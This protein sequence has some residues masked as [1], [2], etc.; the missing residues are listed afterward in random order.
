MYIQVI[1]QNG[2]FRVSQEGA[3]SVPAAYSSRCGK[4]LFIE[5]TDSQE[6]T[7]HKVLE[8]CGMNVRGTYFD[9]LSDSEW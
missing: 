7:I 4:V 6:K 5:Q 1:K 2:G 9:E 3:G 8:F